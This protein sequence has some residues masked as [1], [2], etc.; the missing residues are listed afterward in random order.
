MGWQKYP[1]CQGS[2]RFGI[3]DNIC[4][5]C[6][7]HGIINELTGTAPPYNKFATTTT[8]DFVKNNGTL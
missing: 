1:I 3:T 4:H 2:G 7:G 8:T 6:N 5:V